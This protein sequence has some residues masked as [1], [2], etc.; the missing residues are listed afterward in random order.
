[1]QSNVA[2]HR[3]EA[4]D[5][6]E[7]A[8]VQDV[9]TGELVPIDLRIEEPREQVVPRLLSRSSSTWLKYS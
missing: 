3:V 1:M 4:G 8:D 6:E 7:E 9:L 2:R 5:E